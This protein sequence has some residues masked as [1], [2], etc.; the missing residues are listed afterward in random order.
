[1]EYLTV[2]FKSKSILPGRTEGIPIF[3][4]PTEVARY[5]NLVPFFVNSKIYTISIHGE[6]VPLL[7]DL[8]DPSDKLI[9]MGST[10][11]G[12]AILK[13]VKVINNSVVAVEVKFDIWNRLPYFSK[14]RKM[15]ESEFDI[16]E[17]AD[18]T[19]EILPYPL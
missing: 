18:V 15:L 1:M 13:S 19:E 6:G 5:D 3:F 4:H 17:E 7:I 2:K 12:K 8:V 16:E 10:T 14:Q 9:D 11:A